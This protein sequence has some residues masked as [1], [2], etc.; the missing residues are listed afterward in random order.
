M[1]NE[2]Y[3]QIDSDRYIYIYI[4]EN[5]LEYSIDE[6]GCEINNYNFLA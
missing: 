2:I 6:L 5:V 4:L 1:Q 3:L